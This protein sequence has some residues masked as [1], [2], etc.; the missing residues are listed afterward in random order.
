[1][2]RAFKLT[3]Y[4]SAVSLV[5]IVLVS[6]VLSYAYHRHAEQ[7]L[8]LRGDQRN[9]A[10]ARLLV[11]VLDLQS[12]LHLA[13]TP[14]PGK[15]ATENDENAQYLQ[16]VL[17]RMMAGTTLRKF[18]FYNPSGQVVYSSEAAQTGGNQVTNS[19][20]KTAAAGGRQ[21]ELTRR[22]MPSMFDGGVQSTDVLRSEEHTSELQSQ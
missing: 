20:F 9:Q 3:R 15:P 6:L 7:E 16:R 5:L 11:N 2:N 14:E 8:I 12:G 13:A 10:Q 18:K 1:M 21:V 19:G 4:F 17:Q 22:G